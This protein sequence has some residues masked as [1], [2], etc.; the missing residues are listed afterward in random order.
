MVADA[1]LGTVDI[2]AEPA[3]LEADFR[4]MTRAAMG[5]AVAGVVLRL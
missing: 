3:A 2:A 5:K 1:L 4:A